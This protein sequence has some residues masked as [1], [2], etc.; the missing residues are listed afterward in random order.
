VVTKDQ[1][2]TCNKFHINGCCMVTTVKGKFAN[3]SVFIR[4]GETTI[5]GNGFSVPIERFDTSA[6]YYL[7]DNNAD[8]FHAVNECPLE[9]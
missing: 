6:E 2:L 7:T 9:K 4:V 1:A 8:L 5:N 3:Q